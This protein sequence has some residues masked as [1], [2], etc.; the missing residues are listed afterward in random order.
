MN[1]KVL[2]EVLARPQECARQNEGSC[3]QKKTIEHVFGRKN[4]EAW[5]CIW[6]C[7]YHHGVGNYWNKAAFSKEINKF[8]AY[9]QI[10]DEELM[11]KKFSL[12]LLQE[13]RYLTGKYNHLVK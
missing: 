3:S 1:P 6:L 2:E 4:E 9:Q 8:Y 7:E 12:S 13:K 11:K 5:S 10:T